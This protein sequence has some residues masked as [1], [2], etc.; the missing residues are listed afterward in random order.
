MNWQDVRVSIPLDSR[1]L[2][3]QIGIGV[4]GVQQPVDRYYLKGLWCLHLYRYSA[5]LQLD[6]EHFP[7]QPGYASLLPPDVQQ[8]YRYRGRSVH[9]Y[10]HFRL[11]AAQ[12]T[13][14]QIPIMQ[15]L[16][17][18]F[19]RL[20]AAMEHAMSYFPI[21]PV[22]AEVHLWD[23]LWQLSSGSAQENT[24]VHP[25]VQQALNRIA[26]RL[27]EK[28]DIDALC[29]EV[30]V[31]HNHLTRLFHRTF[32]M[33]ISGYIQTQRVERAKHLLLYS[34]LPI[35]AIAAEVG[36]G[37]VHLFNKTIRRL[38]GVSPSEVRNHPG[39]SSQ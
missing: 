19:D 37:D 26:L 35:K 20:N 3:S 28:I 31:S 1:P 24:L 33:T 15:D 9:I 30:D 29:R 34:T 8:E 21:Q 6:H 7:I 16:A 2:I 11:A 17:D 12:Q 14:V 13:I 4:H 39:R 5:D 38:L 23:L 10:A 32:G 25:A 22:R 27:G 36:I 18:R